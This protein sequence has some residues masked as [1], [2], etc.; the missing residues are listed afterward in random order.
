MNRFSGLDEDKWSFSLVAGF[1]YL[2][3]L[4]T[5]AMFYVSDR[6]RTVSLS[7]PF[8]SVD[9]RHAASGMR[10]KTPEQSH[11]NGR[12]YPRPEWITPLGTAIAQY[13][14]KATVNEEMPT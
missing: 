10:A 2:S 1:L 3:L 8:H 4:S 9:R 14:S 13:R 6:I 12:E 5:P 11:I 7:I